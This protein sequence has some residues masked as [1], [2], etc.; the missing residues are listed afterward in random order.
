MKGNYLIKLN[1]DLDNYYEN[2]IYDYLVE[3]DTQRI[4]NLIALEAINNK[5]NK[6]NLEAYNNDNE[7]L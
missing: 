6:E 2:L 3:N 4:K 7:N 5:I 1:L